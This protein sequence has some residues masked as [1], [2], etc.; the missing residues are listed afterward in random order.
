MSDLAVKHRATIKELDTDYMEQRQQELIRQA[1]RRKG[2]Y[3]RLGFM[4]VVFSVLAIC[5]SVTLFS[6]RA[7]INEKRQEQQAA[8]EQLE[9]LKNEEEQLLRDIANFQDDEFIKE[10][11]RRDYYLTLPG[12]TR[13]N[14]S[15]QQSSD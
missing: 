11:A 2:L 3:R 12:E 6:Q 10:I 5:C 13:I 9:Q 1:K 4:G 8:A 7:D 14:V 15:K